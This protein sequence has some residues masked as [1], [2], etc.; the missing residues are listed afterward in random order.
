MLPWAVSNL[1]GVNQVV[2]NL[3]Q[4]MVRSGTFD[5]IILTSDWDA[6][7][8]I[9]ED[10]RGLRVVRWRLRFYQPNAGLKVRFAYACWEWRF[11]RRF[12]RFCREHRVAVVNPHY[13]GP[14]S[15]AIERAIQS[16]RLRV[17]ILFSFHGADLTTIQNAPPTD[18]S[19]WRQAL[20]CVHGVVACSRDLGNKLTGVFGGDLA[21]KVIH[22]GL[23]VAAFR[24][25]SGTPVALDGRII[26]NVAKFEEKKGQDILVKAFARIAAD[27]PDVNLVLVG[28]TARKL[29]TLR[30]LCVDLKIDQRVLFFPDTPH[31]Q[32]V[33]FFRRAT[34][35]ALPSRQEPFGIV[36]LEAGAFGLPVVASRVGGIPE[37]L[38]DG[39][40]G[41][42]VAPDDE[43]ELAQCLASLLDSPE[44]S[45]ELG[46]RLRQ[47][48]E[49]NFTWSQALT[50]Y[51]A[52]TNSTRA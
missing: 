17:S 3:A 29:D 15:L 41:R 48:V 2:L 18:F 37:I 13:P 45:R 36:L 30:A 11:R 12:A 43:V 14:T 6:I 21:V 16:S 49:S 7:D 22:N 20:R 34:I 4:E 26:L 32:V 8:P 38:T 50:K 46:A 23:D 25:L 24:N 39:L 47:H 42:L 27:Y 40:T 35:F 19:H 28:A 5:P 1:G 52:F 9:F 10:V 31:H 44:S 33:E 51:L